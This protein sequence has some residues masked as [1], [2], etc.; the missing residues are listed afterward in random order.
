MRAS[1]GIVFE[2]EEKAELSDSE[3]MHLDV[4]TVLKHQVSLK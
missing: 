2:R 4:R 1:E 3:L